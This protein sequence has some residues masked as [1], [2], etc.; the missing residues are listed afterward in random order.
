[1]ER[2]FMRVG[3]TEEVRAD[4]R[5]I[6]AT[7]RDLRRQVE[8]GRFRDDLYY[9]LAVFPIRIPSLGERREDIPLLARRFVQEEAAKQGRALTLTADAEARL[10]E[11][12][13]PGNVRQLRN[14]VE[15]AVILADADEID[16]S[17][18]DDLEPAE[19]APAGVGDEPRAARSGE[20]GRTLLEIGRDAQRRAESRAILEALEATGGNR[21]EAARRL[22]I[23]YKTLWAKC[24]EYELGEE[25]KG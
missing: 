17:C 13:W 4:I 22:G 12:A 9:R 24:K 1:Q 15:R 20:D 19:P 11:A 7:N 3:G 8:E 21:T 5:V 23:S 25:A 6:A 18:F 16:A 10:G 2:T 14:V